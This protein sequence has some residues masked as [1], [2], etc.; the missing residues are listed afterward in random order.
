VEQLSDLRL[1]AQVAQETGARMEDI[2]IQYSLA[3]P[4]QPADPISACSNSIPP[5]Y[6]CHDAL[7]RIW[8]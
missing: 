7:V 1:M 8:R 6:G 5:S 4:G 2:F 3:K